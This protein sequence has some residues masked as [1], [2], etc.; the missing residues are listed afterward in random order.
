MLVKSK[1]MMNFS[2][3]DSSQ[4]LINVNNTKT[5]STRLPIIHFAPE[6]GTTIS[7]LFSS[8]IHV[9]L[10]LLEVLHDQINIKG[11]KLPPVLL[12]SEVVPIDRLI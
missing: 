11:A 12:R 8:P 2:N 7:S 9:Q 10:Q 5:G 3:Y 6:E 1:S 4:R